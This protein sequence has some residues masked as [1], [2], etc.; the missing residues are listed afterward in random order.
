MLVSAVIQIA[1]KLW[2]SR[3]INTGDW[4]SEDNP[5]TPKKK[6]KVTNTCVVLARPRRDTL[7]NINC[8]LTHVIRR[9]CFY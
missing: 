3:F 2:G 7:T 5:G 4:M 1:E 6:K 8:A 9:L